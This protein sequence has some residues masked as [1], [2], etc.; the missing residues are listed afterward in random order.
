[1]NRL[2]KVL[3]NYLFGSQESL[4]QQGQPEHTQSSSEIRVSK[5]AQKALDHIHN[6]APSDKVKPSI[7]KEKRVSQGVYKTLNHFIHQTLREISQIFTSMFGKS[8]TKET[9]LPGVENTLTDDDQSEITDMKSVTR[10]IIHKK[11]EEI[12]LFEKVV[13]GDKI[14]EGLDKIFDDAGVPLSDLSAEDVSEVKAYY[15]IYLNKG[16]VDSKKQLYSHLFDVLDRVYAED[17]VDPLLFDIFINQKVLR[18]HESELSTSNVEELKN[19]I[20]AKDRIKNKESDFSK[21][22]DKEIYKTLKE[23]LLQNCTDV[24]EQIKNMPTDEIY[25]QI[26]KLVIILDFLSEKISP[27]DDGNKD[28]WYSISEAFTEVI[29][30]K[31][32]ESG[33]EMDQIIDSLVDK[34][35]NLSEKILSFQ[36]FK[37]SSDSLEGNTQSLL[38]KSAEEMEAIKAG[39]RAKVASHINALQKDTISIDDIEK[40]HA[41]NNENVVPKEY[42]KIRHIHKDADRVS[43][44]SYLLRVGVHP[45]DLR[46]ELSELLDRVNSMIEKDKRKPLSKFQWSLQV[47]KIHNDF[48]DIHPFFDRNGST[49][50][51][52][53]EL[54]MKRKGYQLPEERNV[55]GKNEGYYSKLHSVLG[56]PIACLLVLSFHVKMAIV[57]GYYRSGKVKLSRSKK[58][59]YKNILEGQTVINLIKEGLH[60]SPQVQKIVN[61]F[62][63]IKQSG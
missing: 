37:G 22:L 52:I 55:S 41:I 45:E 14:F 27:F 38:K 17:D 57:P 16:D 8:P 53:A 46:E 3:K 31:N 26:E 44:V 6:K 1:M 18:E 20:K 47:A 33:V 59:F 5:T 25:G 34:Y 63:N 62:K 7:H 23:P 56:N 28:F 48:L 49:A 21:Y 58:E 4:I 12:Y 42:S 10:S 24:I 61:I 15:L 40:I 60:D 54:L 11:I 43:V 2:N 30:L 13:K 19:Y 36:F 51:L 39:N 29:S 9:H 32:E 35:K 50:L